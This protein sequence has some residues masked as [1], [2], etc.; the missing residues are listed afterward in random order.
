MTRWP[1][2]VAWQGAAAVK[3]L[4]TGSPLRPQPMEMR[5]RVAQIVDVSVRFGRLEDRTVL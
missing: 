5:A 2:Q 3:V 1:T 4:G